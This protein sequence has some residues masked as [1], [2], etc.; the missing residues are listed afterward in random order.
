MFKTRI[1]GIE[2][3]EKELQEAL[4]NIQEQRSKVHVGAVSR[5]K[6]TGRTEYYVHIDKDQ[7]RRELLNADDY[8]HG[9]ALRLSDGKVIT[10]NQIGDNFY[11]FSPYAGHSSEL[12][13]KDGK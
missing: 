6:L 10:S 11:N 7:V 9:L 4:G 5:H 3:T 12:I 2:V 1:K 13:L 8:S